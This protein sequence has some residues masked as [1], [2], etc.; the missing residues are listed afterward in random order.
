MDEMR[1]FK[2]DP[3]H[4]APN[5]GVMDVEAYVPGASTID[6]TIDGLTKIYKL[7]SNESPLGPPPAAIEAYKQAIENMALY[8]DGQAENL[9][10]ALAL[11]HGLKMENILCG[12]G[13]DELLGLL[14]HNYLSDGDEVIMTQ[15]GFSVYDIQ[16]RAAGATIIKVK[17]KD[18]RIDIEAV[19]AALTPKTKLIFIANPGNPTGTYLTRDEVK[20]L[21]RALPGNVLLVLDGAYAEFV[22]RADYEP[23]VGLVE[24]HDNVVMTR[25]FSKIYGLAGLRIG[26]MY[27]PDGVIQAIERVRPPFNVALPAQLAAAKACQDYDFIAKLRQFNTKWRQWLA[28]ELEDLGLRVTPSVA[29]F[30]LIHFH[31]DRPDMARQADAYLRSRGFILRLVAGYGFPNALRLSIG[32]EEANRGVIAALTDFMKLHD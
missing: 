20:T 4:P 14:A 5:K 17:E 16:S 3:S 30:L 26:W 19:R 18:C 9:R 11:A 28:Q 13:S 10:H 29:N 24:A 21:H 6:G 7:S 31:D 12:N 25:T 2:L 27:A 23:G 32:C 1:R 15:H 22:D 8:P